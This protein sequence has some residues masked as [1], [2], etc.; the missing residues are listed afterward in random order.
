MRKSL[1]A[2]AI[3]ASLALSACSDDKSTNNQA[4]TD[5]APAASTQGQAA[6]NKSA[7]NPLLK[8]SPLQYEAPQFDLV[9]IE[10]FRP[11]FEAGLKAH[12]EEIAAI[13]KNPEP[14][15]FDNTIVA[16][17]KT[18]ALLSRVARVFF[19]LASLNSNEEIQAIQGEV[20][21][22]MSEHN[23]NIYLNPELFARVNSIYKHKS[24]LNAEDQRLIDFYYDQFVRAGARLS[25]QD[26]AQVRTINTELAKLSTEFN[27]NILD[28][29]KNDVV[30]VKDKKELD[31]LSEEQIASLAA[32]AKGAG[33]EGYMISLVN[34]TRNP[35]LGS[36]KNRELR[37]KI[38]ETSANRAADT[39]GPLLV[40]MAEL[41]ADKAKL[42][43]YSD[44]ASYVTAD[45]MAKTP[46]AVYKILDD[47][48]PKAVAKAKVEAAD[49][50]AMIE[51]E[52]G[53]FT[54]QPWD[55]AYYAE[56]VRADKYDLD[57]SEVKPYFEFNRVLNDGLFFAM[58]RLYGIT[59]K[60]RDDLPVWHADVHAY[61]I[62]NA[63]GSSVGLF[64][65]DP[66]AREGKNGGAWMDEYVS[67]SHLLG[68]KP[69]VYNALN[70]PKPAEGQPTLMTF[71]EV[72]T[73]FHEF[74][75][76]VH[77][78]FSQVKYPSL[79]GTATARDFVEFPSQF[80]EDWNIDPAVIANY[81]KHY[82][83]GES[84]PQ[85]LL[86]KILKAHKFNQGFDTTEYLAS[87]LL[88]M[89]WHSIPAGT[90]IE[91]FNA[92]E[93]QALAKHG[94]DFAPVP[95]R[96]KSAYFSHIFAGGYSS[97]YY[98]YLWT[99]VFAADAFAYLK[100][101][102]GLNRENGDEYRKHILSIGNSQDL[103]QAYVQFRD[104]EPSVDA[105]L[106]RR[107]LLTK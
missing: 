4:T 83:T 59:V 51:H 103:M 73:M 2:T 10:D 40:R 61:E 28:S 49:I 30:L 23:D 77:G 107:G 32:A 95:P 3:S 7:T 80:H 48:A 16:M 62:F 86:D 20:A 78:L 15:T 55:W 6:M 104:G 57:E 96:Y 24:K 8:P 100:E 1:I 101:Q 25:E 99:E 47:L 9:K 97:G 93:K 66:Y 94:I 43:G 21:P 14:P 65:L 91:D 79:A 63:D 54:L 37:Q 50:Q 98:A 69:V 70:I 68:S 11:A 106:A 84:I 102:G 22:K 71:D 42:L 38:W 58:Q 12:V 72:S 19:N 26:K 35:I 18:G 13:T 46:Q 82:Q 31:G 33:K 76:A 39:N 45:Q 34:T 27:N 44:W 74:G 75:H 56:K 90:R 85:A 92:F 105:L 29:F 53:D 60:P 88:D 41:R 87:A 81:A 89:E 52:G 17:E 64:Y 5:T 67:Q 36:L